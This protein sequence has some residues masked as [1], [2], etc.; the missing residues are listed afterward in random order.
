MAL[1]AAWSVGYLLY[2]LAL[3]TLQNRDKFWRRMV[4]QARGSLQ[5]GLMVVALSFAANIAPLP[6]LQGQTLRKPA[7]RYAPPQRHAIGPATFPLRAGPPR[8]IHGGT[9]WMRK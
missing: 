5:L 6:E 7:K 1:T 9:R 3:K 4:A 8:R 2:R